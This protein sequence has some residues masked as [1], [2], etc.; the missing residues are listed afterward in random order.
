MKTVAITT[1][2]TSR[3][4]GAAEYWVKDYSD[5]LE[6]TKA[7]AKAAHPRKRKFYALE[8]ADGWN[9]TARPITLN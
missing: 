2:K 4:Q 3:A 5:D 9:M 8:T 1:T 7:A 6:A